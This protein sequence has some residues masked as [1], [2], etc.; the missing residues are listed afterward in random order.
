MPR[1]IGRNPKYRKHRASGQ[2]VVTLNGR[3]VYLGPHGTAA[4]RQEYD[5][6][7]GE[8]LARGRQSDERKSTDL[9]VVELIAA[10]WNHAQSYHATPG[11]H[12][13]ELQHFKVAL[14]ELRRTYGA[15]QVVDFGPLAMK[16]VREQFVALGWSRNYVND[17]TGR[18]KR[19]F[20]WGT[21]NELVSGSVYQAIS[22]IAGLR[23]G[24]TEALE[25]EPVK[26]VPEDRVRA[27]LPL[28]SPQVAAM[29]SLQMLTGMRPGEVCQMRPCDIDT[30]G[31]LW[32]Y[33]PGRHKTQHHGHHRAVYLGEKC[34]R[35]LQLFLARDPDAFLFSPAEAE[36]WRLERR[37]AARKTPLSCGNRAGTD[38]ARRPEKAP[39]SRYVTDS[40]RRAIEYGCD[41]A[42]P[43][44]PELARGEG[45][46][47]AGWKARLTPKQLE[48]L[49]AWRAEHRWHPNQIRHNFGTF[50]RKEYGLEAAQVLL[51]HKTL[52]VTQVYAEKN[53]EA[54]MRI[55][56]EVG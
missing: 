26:P 43:P 3:D 14:R 30:T 42:F 49:K 24:K 22:T 37:T 28:V 41:A 12:P 52:T 55:M 47:I 51:G 6:V 53:V 56:G 20:K 11:G 15:T 36:R 50:A 16:A 34:Q 21:E 40:Y 19:V 9:S 4:S 5:R 46:T 13:A 31:K 33:T 25:T 29:I 45:E 32:V 23:M 44:P 10:Y 48:Q 38:L 2:A 18:L 17:Q 27:V 8:W 1:L 7:L 35:V 54:A 39:S